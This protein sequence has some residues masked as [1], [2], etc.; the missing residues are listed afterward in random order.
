MI[1]SRKILWNLLAFCLA[2][3]PTAHAFTPYSS[4]QSQAQLLFHRLD[5]NTVQVGLWIE[6]K[7]NWHT[8]WQNPGDAGLAPNLD[9]EIAPTI[10]VSDMQYPLPE[11]ITNGAITTFGYHK[12]ALFLRN[13][14]LAE[15]DK[16]SY[17]L[18]AKVRYLVCEQVCIIEKT[19]F[20]T[21]LSGQIL[22]MLSAHSE[23]DILSQFI[24]PQTKTERPISTQAD[25]KTVT[26]VVSP[27]HPLSTKITD[28][29]PARQV[30]LELDPPT[31]VQNDV[32]ATLKMQKSDLTPESPML[33][34]LIVGID[35]ATQKPFGIWY[36]GVWK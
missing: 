22:P 3:V 1:K 18:K 7:D 24:W 12:Q 11:R 29:F 25:S 26:I 31:I 2:I 15:T 21:N 32:T 19:E 23:S 16:T 28:F 36:E 33:K 27:E 35:N 10:P 20:S 13:I 30:A 4:P 5:A 14:T 34:G 8:Y 9:L 17:S 6:L